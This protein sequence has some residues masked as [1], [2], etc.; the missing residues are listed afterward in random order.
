MVFILLIV[1]LVA[2]TEPIIITIALKV[3]RTEVF[4]GKSGP[5]GT[6][7]ILCTTVYFLIATVVFIESRCFAITTSVKTSVRLSK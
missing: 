4:T 1:E 3:T 2:L 5:Y 6:I 7:L